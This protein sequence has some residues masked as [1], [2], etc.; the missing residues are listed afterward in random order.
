MLNIDKVIDDY[1]ETKLEDKIKEEI[2]KKQNNADYYRVLDGTEIPE[3]ILTVSEYQPTYYIVESDQKRTIMFN[4]NDLLSI[5]NLPLL[6][7]DKEVE[8]KVIVK[9][10]NCDNTGKPINE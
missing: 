3:G 10:R 7:E 8:L 2:E 6:P 1:N 5:L 9:G 4:A